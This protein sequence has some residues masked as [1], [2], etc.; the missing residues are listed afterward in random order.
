MSFS[1]FIRLT[2]SRNSGVLP[3]RGGSRKTTSTVLL[4]P[5]SYGLLLSHPRLESARCGSC[6]LWYSGSRTGWRFHSFLHP[7]HFL[8]SCR[9]KSDC[10]DSTVC[11][12]NC[13]RSIETSSLDRRPVKNLRL[14]RVNLIKTR[15]RNP[16][17]DSA[18]FVH[19]I[20]FSVQNLF[21]KAKHGASGS[22]INILHDRTDFRTEFPHPLYKCFRSRKER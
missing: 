19:N 22:V 16:K 5:Q 3:V 10:S 12:Q 21:R 18:K 6:Y 14:H 4:L 1:G 11:I 13:L 7:K 2:A 17:P 20:T 9:R 8:H 15:S